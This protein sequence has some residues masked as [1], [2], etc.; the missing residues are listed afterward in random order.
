MD[1]RPTLPMIDCSSAAILPP[2]IL[3]NR[4]MVDIF[5]PDVLAKAEWP[6]F[7]VGF[8]THVDFH[9]FAVEKILN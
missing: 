6:D 3:A 9:D 4:C 8:N 7:D 2:T 1:S 5:L